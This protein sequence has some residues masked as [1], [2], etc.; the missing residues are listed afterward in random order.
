MTTPPEAPVGRTLS[1]WLE[2]A[3][4]ILLLLAGLLP[5]ARDVAGPFDRGHEGFQAAFFTVCAVNHER[6]G[7]DAFGGYPVASIELG[8]AETALAHPSRWYA[9]P[10]HPPLVP[11]LAWAGLRALG[12]EGWD[13]AWRRS[14]PPPAGT[15]LAVRLPF[16]A[17][18]MAGLA[19]LWWAVRRWGSPRQAMLTLAVA[20]ALPVTT[21][22]A[23]LVN[24]ESAALPTICLAFG[25]HG[26]W[27]ASGRARDLALCG[28]AWALAGAVTYAPLA[29]VPFAAL[30]A[31]AVRGVR[32]G[33][34]AALV[35]GG[36]CLAPLL[37]H[38]L[39]VRRALG[40]IGRDTES[41]GSRPELLL[42]PL[43]DGTG[44]LSLWLATQWDKLLVYL[45]APVLAVA[46]VGLVIAVVRSARGLARRGDV[47]A[48]RDLDAAQRAFPLALPL[49]AGGLAVQLAFYKHTLEEQDFFLL[50]LAP[51][52]AALAALPFDALAPRLFRL[53]GG[54]APLVVLLSTVLL[55]TIP[56]VGQLRDGWR[57]AGPH[58]A[59]PGERG[60][61]LPL[62][63]GLGR[64]LAAVVPPGGLVLYPEA[65]GLHVATFLYAWR[66]GAA[67]GPDLA[68]WGVADGTLRDFAP[69]DAPRFLVLPLHPPAG[70]AAEVEALRAFFAEQV[71]ELAARGPVTTGLHWEAWELTP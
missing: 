70:A 13:T 40:S 1:P 38:A 66:S 20:V 60:P 57:A 11:W 68:S 27:L 44:P 31:C 22:F 42:Q 23:T 51:G 64:D 37:V 4:V 55:P 14:E 56:R 24:Y 58:D 28:G 25:L 29:M 34:R 63:D 61:E 59:P 9:Y 33:V 41:L 15:E 2:R 65:L 50:F 53:R 36:A 21:V 49:A 8:D 16:L 3:G 7:A 69:P 35:Q 45:T 54:L 18:H 43:L 26:R 67:V 62:P 52:V 39:A 30:H 6:L 48:Q 46:C 71:P 32:A 5:R 19:L 17:L 12:P 10:N 47:R